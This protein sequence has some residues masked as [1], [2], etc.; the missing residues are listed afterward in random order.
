MTA[1]N[2]TP[3][4]DSGQ[5]ICDSPTINMKLPTNNAQNQRISRPSSKALATRVR[6][7]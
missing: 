3:S 6:A 2:T 7:A 5:K 4:T 1:Q